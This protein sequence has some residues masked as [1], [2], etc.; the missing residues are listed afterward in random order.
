MRFEI[1]RQIHERALSNEVITPG[2]TTLGDVGWWV[3]EEFYKR[4][5]TSNYWVR[6]ETPIVLYSAVSDLPEIRGLP[7]NDGSFSSSNSPDYILQRGDFLQFD[8]GVQYLNY[9]GTDY[10]RNAYIM[11]EGGNTCSCKFAACF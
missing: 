2:L 8:N 10:K 1:Q 5:L 9:I 7:A 11:R 3:K 6:R 4:N